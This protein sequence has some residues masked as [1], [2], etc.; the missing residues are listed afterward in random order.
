MNYRVTLLIFCACFITSFGL[1]GQQDFKEIKY[2]FKK[3]DFNGTGKWY[4]GR[5]I[6]YVMGYQGIKWLE[7]SEREKEENVSLLIQNMRIKSDDVIADIGAG[8]GYHAFKMAQLARNG[9][10]YAV[11]I[12]PEMLSA[13]ASKKNNLDISNIET[14]LGAEKSINLP[15]HSIDKVLMVD[16]YHEFSFPVEMISSIKNALKPNGLLFL[17]EYRGEDSTV[18]IKKIHKMTEKQSVLEMKAAGFTLKENINNLPWQHCMVFEKNEATRK[19]D[20]N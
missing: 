1:F 14:I 3:G 2:T 16:V 12:Q 11:D 19:K 15:K 9:L 7:R 10:V 20:S 4:M 5:E 17:I 13:I 18:P 8:S 6:A